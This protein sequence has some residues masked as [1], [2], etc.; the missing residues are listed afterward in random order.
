MERAHCPL[1]PREKRLI[2]INITNAA[3]M[4]NIPSSR[5]DSDEDKAL[6]TPLYQQ[7][8]GQMHTQRREWCEW[9]VEV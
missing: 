3:V 5:N 1:K 7:A 8:V 2:N 6:I 9:A 4:A